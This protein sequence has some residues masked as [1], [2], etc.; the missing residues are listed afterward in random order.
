M[1]ARPN[2]F[3]YAT[4][5]LSQDAVLAWLLA[6]ADADAEPHDPALHRLGKAFVAALLATHGHAPPTEPYHV[7]VRPQHKRIDVLFFIGDEYI[8]AI[9]DKTN[10]GPHSDQLTRYKDDVDKLAEGRIPVLV[11]VKT[12]ERR[13]DDYVRSKGWQPFGRQDLLD[14][15]RGPTAEGI[16]NT[17]LGDYV[18]HLV[19][20]NERATAWKRLPCSEP[21]D[22]PRQHHITWAGLYGVLESQLEPKK[23]LGW[24]YVANKA[25]GFMGFWWAFTPIDGGKLYVQLEQEKLTIKVEVKD[26][27]RRREL[28]DRW[29]RVVLGL[30]SAQV[31]GLHRPKRLGYGQYMTI[32]VAENGWRVAGAEGRL[33]LDATVE[34][35]QQA[36]DI[37]REAVD[38]E[39][40]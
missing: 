18:K 9:E 13:E 11:Y 30:P 16:E 17:I 32:A 10:T 27:E 36:A 23:E 35:L 22:D 7:E 31:L 12:G 6:W 20:L 37:V 26:K 29:K 4:S 2:L 40:T 14:L 38:A 1:S 21:W 5:E 15:L 28:R 3:D 39:G 8:V 33:D 19:D 25:G 24:R 34:R